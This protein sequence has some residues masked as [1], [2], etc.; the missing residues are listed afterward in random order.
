MTD[1]PP[2]VSDEQGAQ[3]LADVLSACSP[4]TAS[5]VASNDDPYE[6]S[7]MVQAP[8]FSEATKHAPPSD[9]EFTID[10]LK[11]EAAS[12]SFAL[13]PIDCGDPSFKE[14]KLEFDLLNG[15]VN[16]EYDTLEKT[17]EWK[18]KQDG[19]ALKD[20]KLLGQIPIF[21]VRGQT[22]VDKNYQVFDSVGKFIRRFEKTMD[23]HQVNKDRCWKLYLTYAMAGDDVD[24]WFNK[25]LR[26]QN[27]TWNM[28]KKIL[29]DK[30]DDM[31]SAIDSP[32]ELLSM[33]M[34]KNESLAEFGLRLQ[35]VYQEAGWKDGKT[36]A[37][38]CI[39]AHPRVLRENV[40]VLYHSKKQRHD[41]PQTSEEVLRLAGK[42][43]Q[44]K[45][46]FARDDEYDQRKKA[47]PTN[48][49]FHC[50]YHGMRS[51]HPTADCKKLNG[52]T[53]QASSSTPSSSTDNVKINLCYFCKKAEW[54][55]SHTCK[56]RN[57]RRQAKAPSIRST[58]TYGHVADHGMYQL[59]EFMDSVRM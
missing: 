7:N 16:Q 3:I 18:S 40:L 45:R 23:L 55:P 29:M 13:A 21:Q 44:Q 27:V 11:E 41:L 36:T 51:S 43:S 48:K 50:T 52:I 8:Q 19:R 17:L 58:T 12:L 4:L 26:P 54:T 49:T 46:S 24:L 39:R 5:P 59:N 25:H 33:V 56:E 38:I 9:L 32:M 1:S 37:I 57:V 14:K 35:T 28:A 34:N 31:D 47:F 42:L 53:S 6:D 10:R 2:F 30:F 15:Q 22:Q 20:P